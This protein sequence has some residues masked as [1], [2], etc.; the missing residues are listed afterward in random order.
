VSS[1]GPPLEDRA[2]RLLAELEA[3]PPRERGRRRDEARR[4][5]EAS[6]REGIDLC[7]SR[8]TEFSP[9]IGTLFLAAAKLAWIGYDDETRPA[10]Y[11]RD[12]GR[13]AEARAEY[14]R[15]VAALEG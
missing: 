8:A 3:A 5:A 9:R 7:H 10:H 1:P 11:E 15:F 12:I 13:D 2:H 4:L 14:E 6:K